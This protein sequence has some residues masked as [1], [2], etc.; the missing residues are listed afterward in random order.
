MEN[1]IT[2]FKTEKQPLS[3]PQHLLLWLLCMILAASVCVWGSLKIAF[4]GPSPLYAQQLGDSWQGTKLQR[5]AEHF[6]WTAAPEITEEDMA[7]EGKDAI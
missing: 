1:E 7:A 4:Q 3:L 2:E 5:V 6:G